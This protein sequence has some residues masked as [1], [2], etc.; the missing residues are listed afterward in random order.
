MQT[1]HYLGVDVGTTVIKA[2]VFDDHGNARAHASRPSPVIRPHS[3]WSEQS[4]DAVWQTTADCIADAVSQTGD[5]TIASLGVC[6]QGDGLWTLDAKC[7]PVRNAILWNDARSEQEV[8]GWIQD[9]TSAKL[10]RFCR[11][12]IWSGTAGAAFRWLKTHEPENAKRVAYVLFCKDWINYQLTGKLATDFSDASI[13]FMDLETRSYACETFSLLDIDELAGKL[14]EPRVAS[15]RHGG[16]TEDAAARLGLPAGLPV[17]TGTLDLAAM[18]TALG[19]HNT[20]DI[21]LI[22]GT[23]AVLNVIVDPGPFDGEPVG[24]TLAHPYL[25]KWIRVIA[26]A[27]GAAALDWFATLHPKT[28]AGAS[29]GEI[30]AKLTDLARSSPPGANGVL[31]LPFLAGERA[32]FVAPHASASFLGVRSTTTLADMAHAVIEGTSFSLRHCFTAEG[33]TTSGDAFLTGGGSK[34][35]F[36]CN[37]LASILATPIVANDESDHGLWGAALFGAHAAG[38]IDIN[39]PPKR[40]LPHRRHTPDPALVAAYEKIY[41]VYE[42]AV[43]LSRPL[44]AAQ[45]QMLGE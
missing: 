24:A 10:S 41:P 23:T 27:T 3:G 12:S 6:A 17:A 9:G 22:L 40:P 11:T 37:I 36:W 20:G 8:L 5:L 44:W 19:L 1:Y 4:M 34:N 29:A 30:A 21:C 28:M 43:E 16:L 13:P 26:P 7:K 14:L 42:Q 31:F 38:L 25:D 2:T 39:N 33:T 18:L 32:P 15:A 45:M 35:E